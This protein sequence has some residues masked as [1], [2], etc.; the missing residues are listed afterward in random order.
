MIDS[1]APA[2]DRVRAADSV[3]NHA[4][5]A[6]ELEDKVMRLARHQTDR[7]RRD[8]FMSPVLPPPRTPIRRGAHG[9]ST[10]PVTA[11]PQASDFPARDT[12]TGQHRRQHQIKLLVH[13]APS[14]IHRGR[15]DG[16]LDFFNQ[17]WLRYV[18]RPLEALEGWKW[19][20]FIHRENP[21]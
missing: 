2:S 1:N 20:A 19:T 13:S 16:Y 4:A 11:M 15:P 17:T 9:R 5:K 10:K 18:G 6:I 7:G 3:F 12:V 8:T 21:T 14:M